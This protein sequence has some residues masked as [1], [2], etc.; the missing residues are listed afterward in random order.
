MSERAD[1]TARAE[2]VGALRSWIVRHPINSF[3]VL[4][5]ATTAALACVPQRANG[6]RTASGRSNTSRNS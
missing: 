4:V 1:Q 3:L 5:Y 2:H 6:A